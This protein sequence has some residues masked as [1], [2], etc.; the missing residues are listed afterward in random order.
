MEKQEFEWHE[1]NETP[2]E[3][4]KYII[5]RI[6]GTYGLRAWRNG[7]FTCGGWDKIAAW[8]KI[9]QPELKT[10]KAAMAYASLKQEKKELEREYRKQY[11]ELQRAKQDIESLKKA[12]QNYQNL[13]NK[14][15]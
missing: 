15:I 12:I 10:T 9:P 1:C 8:A 11:I 3:E 4:G 5:Y 7:S 2:T 13:R 14:G 6:T